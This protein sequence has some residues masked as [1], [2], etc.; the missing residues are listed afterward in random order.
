MIRKREVFVD[1]EAPEDDLSEALASML[2]A[3]QFVYE[4][5]SFGLQF[6][7]DTAQI[8]INM[9]ANLAQITIDRHAI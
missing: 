3:Q 8:A 5:E 6:L 7:L 2:H 4:S 9:V 1:Y